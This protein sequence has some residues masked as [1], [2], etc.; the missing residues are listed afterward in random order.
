MQEGVNLGFLRIVRM[1]KIIRVV[2]MLKNLKKLNKK[3]QDDDKPAAVKISIPP[4]HKQLMMMS[5]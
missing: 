2:K 4:V 5:V 3:D 1:M